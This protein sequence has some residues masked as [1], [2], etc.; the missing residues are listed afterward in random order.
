MFIRNPTAHQAV[1]VHGDVSEELSVAT[2]VLR[3]VY[4]LDDRGGLQ[5]NPEREAREAD[6]P[7]TARYALWHEV[8]VTASGTVYGPGKAPYIV[9]V[10]LRVG[11]TQRRLAVFGD[12]HWERALGGDLVSSDPAPFEA[13]PMSFERAFGGSVELAPGPDRVTGLPHPGGRLAFT[14][15]PRG[16][17]FYLD[18]A[19]ALGAPLPNIEAPEQPMLK[20]ND[21][22]E[23]AGFSPCPEL[24]AL[25]LSDDFL[26]QFGDLG[27]E[28]PSSSPWP[29]AA[30][31]P[32]FPVIGL[33]TIHHAH[34]RLIFPSIAPGTRI[35]LLG[36]GRKAMQLELPAPPA[37]VITASSKK[38]DS[39]T[40]EIRRV[41]LRS[42]HLDADDQHVL[43][44]H[45]YTMTYR[46]AFAPEWLH[47]LPV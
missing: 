17:G 44:E 21:Q 24:V 8:S 47:V 31:W 37:K 39:K 7:S 6:P 3:S 29:P 18:E 45:G 1:L 40:G 22:P 20:W 34:G 38:T 12:R 46:R 15:N 43:V 13:M 26:K 30:F 28:R 25:R 23:P 32:V 33:R 35:E 36:M 16:Q 42:V 19:A 11:D 14:K 4:K 10:S 9:P 27:G 2:V 41:E 5:L